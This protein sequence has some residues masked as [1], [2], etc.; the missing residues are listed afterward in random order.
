MQAEEADADQ[1]LQDVPTR[2]ELGPRSWDLPHFEFLE[3]QSLHECF[4]RQQ[5][6]PSI[7]RYRRQNLHEVA[8]RIEMA[9]EES[10]S[11]ISFLI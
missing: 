3:M 2:P 4:L 5:E 10:E 8:R 1:V 9:E 11:L 6:L 7:D